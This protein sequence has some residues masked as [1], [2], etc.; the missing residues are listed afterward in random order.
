MQ[1]LYS[2]AKPVE[3]Q[4]RPASC[5]EVNC[6]TMAAGF[7]VNVDEATTLGRRQAQYLRTAAG[8]AYTESSLAGLTAFTFPPGEQCFAG[9][10]VSEDRPEFYTVTDRG[11]RFRHTGP[12]PWLN[13][14]GDHLDMLRKVIG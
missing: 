5:D 12:D 4:T 13:D 7:V 10:R 11:R 6:P 9:H 3:T 1:K 14:C 2:I 8:R